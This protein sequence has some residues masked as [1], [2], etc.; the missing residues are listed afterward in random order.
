MTTAATRETG[1]LSR[2]F[3]P[4]PRRSGN[5]DEDEDDV[6]SSPVEMR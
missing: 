6:P 2:S 5:H 3:F 1:E 4:D